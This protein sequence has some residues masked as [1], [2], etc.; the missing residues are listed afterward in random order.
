LRCRWLCSVEITEEVREHLR[1]LGLNPDDEIRR[2]NNSPD[3]DSNK[4]L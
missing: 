1:N 3:A 2:C 4:G